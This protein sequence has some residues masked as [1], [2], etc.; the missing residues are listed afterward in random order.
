MEGHLV[1]EDVL[2][3]R[4]FCKGGHFVE[5][6]FVE[7]LNVEGRFVKR[8]FCSEGHFMKGHFVLAPCILLSYVHN[9]LMLPHGHCSVRMYC[10]RCCTMSAAL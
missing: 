2:Y 4:T 5:G 10:T 8:M 7:G 9:E 1:A 6:C 3:R